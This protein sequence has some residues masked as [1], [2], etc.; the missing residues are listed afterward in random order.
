MLSIIWLESLVVAATLVPGQGGPTTVTN[1][2]DATECQW[3][4][5]V[6]LRISDSIYCTGT[7]IHPQVIM[8][9][10]H[11]LDP[12]GGWGVP[13]S[14]NFGE[15]G[16]APTLSVGIQTCGIHP[17]YVH[18]ARLHSPADAYDLA[19]CILDSPVDVPPTPMIMGCEVEQLEPDRDVVIVGFGA[20]SFPDN[21]PLDLGIKR[22]ST[23]TLESID[24]DDQVFLLGDEGSACSGDSGGPAYVQLADGS[25]RVIGA[26][27]R[28]HPDTPEAPPFCVYGTVYTGAWDVMEWYE[29]E[30]DFDLTPCYDP[31]G[32]YDPTEGCGLFPTDPLAA[33]S[34]DDACAAQPLGTEYRGCPGDPTPGD[35]GDTETTA[36]LD[37]TSGDESTSG[38]PAD[39]STSADHITTGG[40]EPMP[41]GSSSS[42]GD[43]TGDAASSDQEQDEDDTGCSCRTEAP[44]PPLA[45]L[46]AVM[47]RRRR[48]RP[49]D[50]RR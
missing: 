39:S 2:Q 12:A 14:V 13:E 1:G 38:A 33:A 36:G 9:A 42:S 26:T 34:W 37:D 48:K 17:L 30:T 40:E 10:A 20:A 25:W 8:T 32:T 16:L 23:Q 44:S 3:P 46:L 7:L 28:A 31:D 27:A 49:A 41:I 47:V 43:G 4:S 45:L 19:Y 22:W 50:S 24:A 5:T 11:C 15:D 18:E 21:V 35:T 6:A 29:Q